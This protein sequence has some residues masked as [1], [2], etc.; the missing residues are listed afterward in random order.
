MHGEPS[1]RDDS[2]L[3]S[4]WAREGNEDAF[5]EIVR[6]YQRLVLGAALR[7]TGD[8]ELARDVAQQVFATL[9]AKARTLLGRTNVAGWLYQAA[10]HIGA[11]AA[12]AEMRRRGAHERSGKEPPISPSEAHWPLVEDALARLGESERESLV[13]HFFQDLSYP[14][15]AH[16]LSIEEAAAR[17]RVSRALQNLE[18]QLR[19][20]G[21]G[22]SATALLT[23]AVAQQ[24]SIPAQAGL[25]A[26]TLA[27]T[28]TAAV[29]TTLMSQTTL[30]VVCAA[31]L[32]ATPLA[33]EWTANA[34]L[35]TE[36][37][38]IRSAN[39]QL[40]ALPAGASPGANPEALLAARRSARIAAENRVSELLAL[41]EKVE[42]EVVVSFGTV[43]AMAKKMARTLQIME[44]VTDAQ[45]SKTE[46]SPEQQA[47][48]RARAENAAEG[49][50][51]FFGIMPEIARLERA[52]EKAARFYA[53]LYGEM[54]GLDEAART[55][56]EN[57]T[58]DWL[59]GLQQ[60]GLALPQ[61]P[62]GK[63]PEWDTRR[64]AATK[65]LYKSLASQLP[66]GKPIPESFV[67]L[68]G[69]RES[70][71]SDYEMLGG[72]GQP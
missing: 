32:I 56:V 33:L 23:A 2:A 20:R 30:K 40:A 28:S 66:P 70:G 62:K 12:Q 9:A 5:A 31:A 21:I 47:A 67:E 39:P 19:R 26:A 72:G 60:E 16:A 53:T 71:S 52:P 46:L 34:T 4:Q 41:K 8:A 27:T 17:K 68:F 43:D 29:L 35:R 13:L 38:Q 57:R 50:T 25:A 64:N 59:R 44:S 61:R 22:T 36:I 24:A 11:R 42:T 14:E 37:A 49:M 63:A 3:L 45:G 54:T 10:S 65:Q 7:R 6:N 48:L 55:L 69:G 1:I 51:D 58:R 18:T 15:M